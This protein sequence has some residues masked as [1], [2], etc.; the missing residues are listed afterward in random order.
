MRAG[1]VL[2]AG[3]FNDTGVSTGAGGFSRRS[4]AGLA[5]LWGALDIG[6]DYNPVHTLLAQQDPMSNGLL[7]AASGF[8]GNAS[9]Q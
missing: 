9:A 3:F 1:F 7:S 2:E 8:M 5:G 4:I 6:L